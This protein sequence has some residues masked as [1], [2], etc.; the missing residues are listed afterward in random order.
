MSCVT[1][2]CLPS[3]AA[4]FKIFHIWWKWLFWRH[5]CCNLY[6]L[7]MVNDPRVCHDLTTWPCTKALNQYC[8]GRNRK[9]NWLIMVLCQDLNG[10]AINPLVH[11][12]VKVTMINNNTKSPHFWCAVYHN[13]KNTK[14]GI[15]FT[16]TEVAYIHG[17]IR[18]FSTLDRLIL[19]LSMLSMDALV[20]LLLLLLIIVGWCSSPS[21]LLLYAPFWFSV[22][23]TPSSFD[24]YSMMT[25]SVADSVG[26][27]VLSCALR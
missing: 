13:I 3:L 20:C 5:I 14:I 15:Y 2:K 25:F 19:S 1:V 12:H 6:A 22:S 10:S 23:N 24:E 9:L 18:S 7:F 26:D 27:V 11:I 4:C 17:L 21:S 8:T 16:V